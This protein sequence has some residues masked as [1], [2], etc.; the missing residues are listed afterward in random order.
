MECMSSR[1]DD[2]EAETVVRA[3]GGDHRAFATLVGRYQDQVFRFIL[4]MSGIRDEAMDLTQ[5]TFMK[6]WLAL[7]AWRPEASFRTWLFQIARHA[8]LDVMRRRRRAEFVPFGD[9]AQDGAILD[10]PDPAPTPEQSL[11]DRQRTGLLERALR[12]L[13]AEQREILLLREVE[14]MSYAEIAATLGIGDGTVKSR[15]ARARVAALAYYRAY[16]GENSH[17]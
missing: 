1:T 7:P 6:A 17:E 10:P 9:D 15:L 12:E 2:A 4:R 13:P 8:T 16:T 14:A 5:D 11:A 3:Q